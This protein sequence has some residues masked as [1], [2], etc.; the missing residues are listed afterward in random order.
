[1]VDMESLARKTVEK[2]RTGGSSDCDVIVT[3]SRYISV[4]I[5]RGSV[6]QAS[7]LKDPGVGI[8]TYDRG[9]M[10]F[11]YCTGHD[12]ASVMRA[13]E[14]ASSLAK[15]GTPDPD[16]K[17]LPGK[18]TPKPMGGLFEKRLAEIEP[19]DVVDMVM[20]M[21]RVAE[22]DKR[23]TSVNANANVSVCEVTLA[24]SNGFCSH[25]AMT[26]VDMFAEAVAKDGTA[27]FSGY[28]ASSSRRLE[29]GAANKVGTSAREHAI[30]GLKQVNI[31]TGD[32]PV[33]MDPLGFGYIL[34][35]AVG[36]GANAESIQRKRSYLVDKLGKRIGSEDL[37]VSDEPRIEWAVGSTAFDGE[38][39]AAAKKKIIDRGRLV[40]YLHDSYTAGKDG[41]RSTGNSSRGG[42]VWTYRAPPAISTTNLVVAKGG[43]SLDEMIRE[44]RKGVYLRITFDRPNLA[45]GEFSGLM[46]EGYSVEKGELGPLVRQST[47]GIGLEDLFSRID[48]VG[49]ERRNAFGV[50]TPPVRISKARVAGSG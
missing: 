24:N 43:S 37:S 22:D 13:A 19:D 46:M 5:E 40:S 4:D 39:T 29:R 20:D 17:G 15:A 44:T 30:K 32:Y 34:A 21:A 48:M 31:P 9:S 8:R 33:I 18:S 42:S 6:K 23:V 49:R 25:Q 35:H 28:D 27:M 16:F 38:G 36:G 45:T 14:L 10:G 26:S 1:M 41:I 12:R 3:N 50:V 2:L 7:V 47:L 11:A